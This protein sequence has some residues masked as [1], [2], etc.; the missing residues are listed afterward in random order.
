MHVFEFDANIV[1]L[2]VKVEVKNISYGRL[3][4]TMVL[5]SESII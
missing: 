4:M 5:H 3:I 2:V 1:L